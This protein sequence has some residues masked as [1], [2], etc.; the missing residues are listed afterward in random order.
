[1]MG[2]VALG[3]MPGTHETPEETTPRGL[4]GERPVVGET[5]ER[6]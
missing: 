3:G 6:R 5:G 2:G 1:M 4:P